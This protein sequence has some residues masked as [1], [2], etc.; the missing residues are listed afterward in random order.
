MFLDL[1]SRF[2]MVIEISG[3]D[4]TNALRDLVEERIDPQLSALAGVSD[5]LIF[6]G[7]PREVR[8]TVD[9][10]RLAA[11]GVAPFELENA[12]SRAV[13][14]VR[15]VG[16]TEDEAGRT[17][18]LVDGRPAG[19][20]S[21]AE[22]ALI[23]TRNLRLRHVAEVAETVAER[24]SVYRVNG[25]PAVALVVFKDEGANLVRL[26][27]ALRRR[28]REIEREFEPYGLRFELRNDGAQLV[29]D[30]LERLEKLALTGFL[31]ALGALFLF[32]RRLR[33][34][35]VVAIAVPVSLLIALALLFVGGQSLNLI[36]LS[37]LA[38]GVG[39]LVD[40]SI[41]VYEA[42]QRQLE[43]GQS[44]DDA[45]E[46]GVQRTIRAILA[47]TVTNAIVFVPL[48][49]L[50]LDRVTRAMLAVFAA[51]IV[52]PLLASLVVAVGLVP[53]LARYL[54]APAAMARLASER[55]RR[56]RYAGLLPPDRSRELFGGVL[57]VALRH[58]G[59]WLAG[60]ALAVL[61][62]AIVGVKWIAFDATA[63]EAAE[64]DEV[65][66]EIELARE[67][68]L[69]R[70]A[71]I[72]DRLEQAASEIE[73]VSS[74]ASII[75]SDGG[76][77]TVRLVDA[78]E[79]PEELSIDLVRSRVRGAAGELRHLGA[80][81]V[82]EPAADGGGSSRR[83]G[84]GPAALFG[85]GDEEIVVSGPD[86]RELLRFAEQ[87][88]EGLEKIP[89]IAFAEPSSRSG[90]QEIW[91]EPSKAR[92]DAVGLT[93]DQVLPVLAA[94]RRDGVTMQTRWS[95]PDGREIPITVRRS[96]RNNVR[97]GE[98]ASATEDLA[99]L[100]VAS[101]AGVLPL[102]ALARVRRM[103][104]RPV[105][106][107]HDGR[108]E[109]AVAYR[110][111]SEAP[112][113]GPAR[114][115]LDQRLRDTLRQLRRPT[116]Y[117][118]DTEPT[119]PPSEWF[120]RALIPVIL[121]MYA[122]L[123]IVFESL[124]LPALVLIALPLTLVGAVWSLALA[125]SAAG[126]M[127]VV[128]VVALIGM[129][130]NPAILLVDRMEQRARAGAFTP[131]AA[132]LAAV[133]ERARPVLMTTTTTVA[134]LWPLA[135][136]TGRQNEIWPPFA[137]V[138]IGGLIASTLLTLL[139]I[140]VGFV[141]VRRLDTL[142]GRLGA[143]IVLGWLATTAAVVTPLIVA[144]LITSM[145]WQIIT[146]VLVAALLLGAA[147]WA[148][149]RDELPRPEVH[150]DAP[151]SFEIRFLHKTYGEP[152]PI[153]SAW[154]A[155]E[156]FARRVLERGAIPFDPRQALAR[157]A[158]L[159]LLLAGAVFLAISLQSAFWRGAFT[160]VS[161]V[162]VVALARE[163]RRARGRVDELGR[164]LDGG[165]EGWL[166][167]LAPWAAYGVIIERFYARPL[168][169]R[170]LADVSG[171]ELASY[172]AV[173]VLLAA[174][175]AF[176]QLG[177]RTAR[178]I[179]A[180]TLREIPGRGRWRRVRT[181]WRRISRRVLGLDLPREQVRALAEV[182]FRAE[183][184]MIGVLGPNGA[185]KTTLLRLLAG[186][187]EPSR[188]RVSLGGVPIGRLRRYLARWVGY[189]PQDFGLPVNL[190]AREYLEY[191]A[192]LY[193]IE[194]PAERRQRV[195]RLLEEVGLGSRAD[196]RI[197]RYSGGMRQRVAV[198]RTLLRLPPVI[199][200]DEPTVGLDPRE[201]IRFRNLLSRLA[202][203][204]VVLFS[205]HVVEDVAVA[206]RRVI[207]LARG[208]IVFDGPPA[209]LSERARGRVWQL[210]LRPGQEA[211]LADA[212]LVVDE[213]PLED[214]SRR[215]RVVCAVPPRADAV[216]T[217][218]TLEDGYLWLVGVSSSAVEQTPTRT[219]DD[220]ERPK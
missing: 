181:I 171:W 144:D 78:H 206:C 107:H 31:I 56:Q 216:P 34:V 51:A 109:M 120:R 104:S 202:E 55:R 191:F 22:V 200:V 61:L 116:G 102:S 219:A 4:D 208:R 20:V 185:G 59:S 196:E 25:Q 169:D 8:V 84:G 166:A 140:P 153:G 118:L 66:L 184:G 62:S 218:P 46:Q 134:G 85:A 92:L 14:R 214:G 58:P 15:Y 5:I 138:V 183:R 17:A 47:G 54:V 149:R 80:V 32:L 99:D 86:A 192:M 65:R 211:A 2:V 71:A 108:R 105:I 6:G 114:E 1:A 159:G 127:A 188:G 161:A 12:I 89:E 193:E 213:V 143:W 136:V 7:S 141:L 160:L 156:R 155:P 142:F 11:L 111:K 133:R 117:T 130:V 77:L 88:A 43:R 81:R 174:A 162:L 24:D 35:L 75:Q 23:S 154:R 63:A 119:E 60:V 151:P 52:L 110:F 122:V 135:I 195:T 95:L 53:L 19:V 175:L 131:G 207:V 57:M 45:S 212:A 168:R 124:V 3:G 194:P 180:G 189:L 73:G 126:V 21:L 152:G 215:A 204:R 93:A 33:A 41:V 38:I 74:V 170:E 10:D 197:G 178:R 40:N 210:V 30:Q 64:A 187:L 146:S 106:E 103:P 201:R 50:D 67:G 209:E 48:L 42:V 220:T 148:F 167:A 145:R 100:R 128:G 186:I 164:A 91:V 39:M 176:V 203:G 101:P 121:L 199:I 49:L 70:A 198:A 115:Q 13:E 87:I 76:S 37:G 179:A 172:A 82:T 205:T 113:V 123:A 18:I 83:S 90:R 98:P 96:E 190:T 16:S 147:A 129:T 44:A 26:G 158:P 173:P 72:F 68:T 36:T 97:D 182:E 69:E 29:E 132:A 139:V 28:V 157:L 27:R 112:Q 163:M 79:R 165:A 137:T 125:G 9:P 217:E 94:L 150:D 177:R